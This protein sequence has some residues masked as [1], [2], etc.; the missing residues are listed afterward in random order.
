[1]HYVCNDP[2][3]FSVASGVETGDHHHTLQGIKLVS[4]EII[5]FVIST[6]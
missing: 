6:V 1:M 5:M 2:E 3:Y 4:P